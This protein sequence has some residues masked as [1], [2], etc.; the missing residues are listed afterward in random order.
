[1]PYQIYAFQELNMFTINDVA[2]FLMAISFMSIALIVL[3]YFITSRKK[4]LAQRRALKQYELVLALIRSIQ[5]HRGLSQGVISGDALLY[6]RLSDVQ[7]EISY[8]IESLNKSLSGALAERWESFFDHWSRLRG[9]AVKCA[10]E[11]SFQQHNQMINNLLYLSENICNNWDLGYGKDH[12]LSQGLWRKLLVL[13]E[14]IGQSRAL[15]AS[16][17][18]RGEA[19]YLELIRFQLLSEKIDDR[20]HSMDHS[21]SADAINKLEEAVQ[22]VRDA[23]TYFTSD[24]TKYPYSSQEY[25]AIATTSLD[26]V[27]SVLDIELTKMK[28]VLR[29]L[30]TRRSS[31]TALSGFLHNGNA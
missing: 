2:T 30:P 23:L 21:I 28:K 17:L 16:A 8:L 5:Q 29:I 31:S 9:N 26:H 7:R 24:I 27:T 25:F 15:G 19:S 12:Q 10:A 1:M 6:N 18:V 13:S 11:D 14:C 3:L 4:Y 20:L 22:P